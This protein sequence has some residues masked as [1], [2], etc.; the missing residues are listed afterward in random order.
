MSG[1]VAGF[2]I[3]RGS[4]DKAFEACLAAYGIPQEDQLDAGLERW[5]FIQP[6]IW[7]GINQQDSENIRNFYHD[8]P[9]MK[10]YFEWSEFD[11][12]RHSRSASENA[13]ILDPDHVQRFVDSERERLSSRC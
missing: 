5:V 13:R 1:M 7:G 6:N 2:Y 4:D 9:V 12:S 10:R 11:L 8:H 3:G